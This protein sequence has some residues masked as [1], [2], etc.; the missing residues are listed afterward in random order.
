MT[1]EEQRKEKEQYD[2]RTF[3]EIYESLNKLQQCELREQITRSTGASRAT[4]WFWRTGKKIPARLSDRKAIS[5]CIKK[6][7]GINAPQHLLFDIK[8]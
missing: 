3:P 5:A 6:V 2:A 8:K 7:L 4:V 1:T